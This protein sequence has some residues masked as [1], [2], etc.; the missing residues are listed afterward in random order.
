MV[1]HARAELKKTW[2]VLLLATVFAGCMGPE[3]GETLKLSWEPNPS[4]E[5]VLGYKIFKGRSPAEA[6]DTVVFREIAVTEP[7]FNP[8][9]PSVEFRAAEDLELKH[10]ALICFRVKAYNEVGDSPF[11]RAACTVL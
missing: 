3:R 8:Q 2:I 1:K 6:M 11:S 10:G 9:A 5:H 4:E 7:G